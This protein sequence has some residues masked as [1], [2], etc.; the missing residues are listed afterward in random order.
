MLSRLQRVMAYCFTFFHNA[1]NPLLRRTGYLISIELKDA[2]QDIYSQEFS[3]LNK[4]GQ[5]SLKSQLQP[6]LHIFVDKEGYLRVGG[7][8]QHSQLPYE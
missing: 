6:P 4:K 7:R 8:L 5:V 2:L 3:D 1:K